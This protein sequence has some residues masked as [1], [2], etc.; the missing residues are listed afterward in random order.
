VAA[1]ASAAREGR[2]DPAGVETVTAALARLEAALR[3]RA[4]HAR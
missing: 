2:L 1:A 4:L 3:A